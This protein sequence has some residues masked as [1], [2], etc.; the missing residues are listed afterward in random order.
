MGD[1]KNVLKFVG[2]IA[3]VS[4]ILTGKFELRHQSFSGN[5]RAG[6]TFAICRA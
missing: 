5:F 3:L 1:S 6:E 2:I 4:Q